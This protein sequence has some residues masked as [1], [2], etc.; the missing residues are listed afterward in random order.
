MRKNADRV[1]TEI[2]ET[3]ALR[4]THQNILTREWYLQWLV[5]IENVAHLEALER[6][7]KL[8]A[9]AHRLVVRRAPLVEQRVLRGHEAIVALLQRGEQLRAVLLRR[10][11]LGA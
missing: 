5:R 8:V 7:P 4:E 6:L 9:C 3:C 11:D 10:I 2:Y 1:G